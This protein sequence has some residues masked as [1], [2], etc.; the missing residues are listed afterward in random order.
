MTVETDGDSSLMRSYLAVRWR[1]LSVFLSV[2]QLPVQVLEHVLVAL[3]GV[4]DFLEKTKSNIPKIS[5]SRN[6]SCES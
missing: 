5:T 1:R 4:H 6:L 3:L 2:M